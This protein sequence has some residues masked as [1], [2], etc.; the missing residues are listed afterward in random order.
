MHR[1]WI[2]IAHQRHDKEVSFNFK[3]N[4]SLVKVKEL[5]K[6]LIGEVS[7]E[8]DIG[9]AQLMDTNSTPKAQQRDQI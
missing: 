6:E 1:S 3:P 5:Y 2:Q 7:K 8:G 9:D 4:D